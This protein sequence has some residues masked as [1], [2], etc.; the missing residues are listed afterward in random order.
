MR[1]HR[2]IQCGHQSS[3]YHRDSDGDSETI[4]GHPIEYLECPVC[5][6]HHEFIET[7]DDEDENDGILTLG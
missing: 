5:G 2:C 6:Y 4:G 1:I 7:Y 3:M